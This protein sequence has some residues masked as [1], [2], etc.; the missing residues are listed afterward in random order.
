MKNLWIIATFVLIV[1]ALGGLF[2]FGHAMNHADKIMRDAVVNYE[3]FQEIYNT[4][5]SSIPSIFRLVSSMNRNNSTPTISNKRR[6]ALFIFQ[7]SF[8]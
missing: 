2:F 4:C 1:F 8:V 7:S 3:E 5:Q 6:S